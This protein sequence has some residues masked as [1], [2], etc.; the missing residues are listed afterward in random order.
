MPLRKTKEQREAARV[1]VDR[2]DR[3]ASA[4]LAALSD[5][6]RPRP[7]LFCQACDAALAPSAVRCDRCGSDDLAL[8][9]PPCP[10]FSEAVPSGI[11][12]RCQ[13][14]SFHRPTSTG[15]F[16]VKG[17]LYG[18]PVSAAVGAAI[19]AAM[20]SGFVYCDNCGARFGRG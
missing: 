7:P 3:E 10:L 9:M 2:L 17:L 13:G 20:P 14:T 12:P 19:G 5:A 11:C 16:A 18:G 6:A 4:R 1:E 15:A 8:T